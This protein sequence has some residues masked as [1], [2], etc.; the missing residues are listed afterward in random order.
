MNRNVKNERGWTKCQCERQQFIGCHTHVKRKT[1]ILNAGELRI[2][3]QLRCSVILYPPI[4]L[5]GG[6]NKSIPPDGIN[7]YRVAPL[8]VKLDIKHKMLMLNI[9]LNYYSAAWSRFSFSSSSWLSFFLITV[10]SYLEWLSCSSRF[11]CC[12]RPSFWSFTTWPGLT[13]DLLSP[14]RG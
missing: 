9:A 12:S 3:V 10:I 11:F 7:R 14:E 13:S 2:M 1:S 8:K 5:F 6:M 4:R